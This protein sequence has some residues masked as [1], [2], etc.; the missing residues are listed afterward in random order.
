MRLRSPAWTRYVRP[1][2]E[3]PEPELVMA[4]PDCMGIEWDRIDGVPVA[5]CDRCRKMFRIVNGWPVP[6]PHFL[7]ALKGWQV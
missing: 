1:V 5:F 7:P 6:T 2:E 3:R 4:C